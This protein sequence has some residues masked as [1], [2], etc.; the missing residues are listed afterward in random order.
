MRRVWGALLAVLGLVGCTVGGPPAPAATP[1]AP[2]TATATLVATATRSPVPTASASPTRTPLSGP[3]QLDQAVWLANPADG[4]LLVIDPADNTVAV[5]VPTGQHPDRVVLGEGA[6]WALDPSSSSL[7]EV[8]PRTYL[9]RRVARFPLYQLN[10]LAVG[11]GAVWLGV[12]ERSTPYVLEPME[13]FTPRGGVLRI[14]PG[15]GQVTGYAAAGPVGALSLGLGSLWALLDGPLG[16]PLA[17]IDPATLAVQALELSGTQDWPFA[18]AF[19]AGPDGLW[20]YSAGFGRLYHADPQGRLYEQAELG[21]HKP[22]G[23]A[24]LLQALGSLWLA[25]PWGRLLRYDLSSGTL[26]AE[27]AIDQ[28]LDGLLESAGAV[29]A[30]SWQDGTLYRIDPRADRVELRVALGSRLQ[31]SPRATPTP[32]RRATRPCQEGPYSRLGV[33]MRAVTLLDP[34]LPNRLHEEPGQA[35]K[36]SGAIQ[37]GQHVKILAGP[38][39]TDYW[40]WWQVTVE[41]SGETGWA[42]EGNDTEYWLIP[43]N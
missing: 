43:L 40:N 3:P 6:A 23:G 21:Q 36:V 30:L 29:W 18:D 26:A 16:T 5:I 35:G 8:D 41:E 13:E 34:G 17:R 12:T 19:L 38:D 33:G 9:I 14:D 2:A 28:P 31:P 25:T 39:C 10:A 1:P 42:A 20:L 27:I 4:N 7:V 37:P 11:L 32:V 15:S 22:L 24:Q